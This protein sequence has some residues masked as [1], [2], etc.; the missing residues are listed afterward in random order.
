MNDTKTGE[1]YR[2]PFECTTGIKLRLSGLTRGSAGTGRARD[3]V[4]H[5]L[6]KESFSEGRLSRDAGTFLCDPNGTPRFP[7]GEGEHD[8]PREVTC[9]ACLDL[10]DRWHVDTDNQQTAP[11]NGS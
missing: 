3:T 1:N 5:L 6:V 9:R 10:M 2:I 8:E 11:G 4:N 7:V